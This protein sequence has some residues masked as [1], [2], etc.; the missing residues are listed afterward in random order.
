[1]TEKKHRYSTTSVVLG[2]VTVIA[3]F[4]MLGVASESW[5][6]RLTLAHIAVKGNRL[7]SEQE[8]LLRSG[9]TLGDNYETID[10]ESVSKRISQQ[11]MIKSASAKRTL[12]EGIS[13][14]IIERIPVAAMTINDSLVFVDEDMR[15]LPRHATHEALDLP[16]VSS[17]LAN[18]KIDSVKLGG[19]VAIARSM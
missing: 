18:G 10:L 19:A 7:V 6:A 9:V 5:Q 4:V 13:I 2:A 12:H 17:C 1:M 8:I 3:V 11:P 15:I 14:D 16:I